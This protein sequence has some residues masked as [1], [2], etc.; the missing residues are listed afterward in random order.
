MPNLLNELTHSVKEALGAH[1]T[2]YYN[3]LV[4][5]SHTAPIKDED[6]AVSYVDSVIKRYNLLKSSQPTDQQ[7]QDKKVKFLPLI[8]QHAQELTIALFS[9]PA[10]IATRLSTLDVDEKRVAQLARTMEQPGRNE[11]GILIS[12]VLTADTCA[13]TCRH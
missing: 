4:I 5:Q 3:E 2:K 13:E 6:K 7:L 8:Q 9:K 10:D 1:L 11:V 12:C